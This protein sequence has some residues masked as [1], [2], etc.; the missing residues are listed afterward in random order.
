MLHCGS[1]SL[2]VARVQATVYGMDFSASQ[3]FWTDKQQ[4][5]INLAAFVAK[6][7]V[8][9]CP[10]GSRR[11]PFADLQQLSC[12]YAWDHIRNQ[13]TPCSA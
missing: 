7:E 11:G 1:Q 6:V 5:G 4:H 10:P 9:H 12:C 3:L 8:K 2:K 13:L